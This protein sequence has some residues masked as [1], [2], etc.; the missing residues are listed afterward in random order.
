MKDRLKQLQE[1]YKMSQQDFARAMGITSGAL[2]NIYSERSRPT[3]N[4]VSGVHLAFPEVS[5]NWLMFGEGEMFVGKSPVSN[6]QEVAS[7]QTEVAS[8]RAM[9]GGAEPQERSVEGSVEFAGS[10]VGSVGSQVKFA[11]HPVAENSEAVAEAPD[12]FSGNG[13]AAE[14][15]MRGES[16]QR[17]SRDDERYSDDE[18]LVNFAF[19]KKRGDVVVQPGLFDADAEGAAGSPVSSALAPGNSSAVSVGAKSGGVGAK[20]SG[21]GAK[22]S[23]VGAKPMREITTIEA[24]RMMPSQ[25]GVASLQPRVAQALNEQ[26]MAARNFDMAARRISEIKIF[27]DDGTYETFLPSRR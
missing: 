18:P 15:N 4:H 26:E 7:R 20:S 23:G 19:D 5:V 12:R 11:G 13:A 22:S 2:S 24:A 14:T 8:R 25:S 6:E 27:Y 16:A 3:A 9:V 17:G 1:T 10:Q 21:I